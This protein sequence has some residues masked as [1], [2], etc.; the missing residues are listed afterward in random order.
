MDE[1]RLDKSKVTHITITDKSS[2]I[3][4][5]G[6]EYF[7]LPEK[8]VTHWFSKDTIYPE[9]YYANGKYTTYSNLGEPYYTKEEIY[10]LPNLYFDG[11][12]LYEKA[13]VNIHIGKFVVKTLYFKTLQEAKNYCNM[14]FPN[15]NTF[16]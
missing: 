2:K 12:M 4:Y 10:D 1:L 14:N 15:V 11:N 13:Y 5:M 16:F 9:A 8:T 3:G 7:L 6:Y